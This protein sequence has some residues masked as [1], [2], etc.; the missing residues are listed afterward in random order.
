MISNTEDLSTFLNQCVD[1]K[2]EKVCAVDTEADSL[3]RYSESLCLVQFSDGKEHVLIDPL[4]INDLSSLKS[5][6]E[7]ATCWM[8]GAD[9]DMHMLKQNLEVIPP[10][11]LTLK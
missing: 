4:A 2:E 3:H 5:Y 11:F 1:G 10:W 8:H 7:N 9:Y 6:L